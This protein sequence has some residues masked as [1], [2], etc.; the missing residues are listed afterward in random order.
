MSAYFWWNLKITGL[1]DQVTYYLGKSISNLTIVAATG[2]NLGYSELRNLAMQPT[3]G[4]I[5]LG[6]AALRLGA[7][8][9]MAGQTLIKRGRKYL[10]AVRKWCH[11]E[12]SRHVKCWN[13]NNYSLKKM[14]YSF[15]FMCI[16]VLHVLCV[17]VCVV[18]LA[19]RRGCCIPWNWTSR[20]LWAGDPTRSSL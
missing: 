8:E 14:T 7:W 19:A 18:A 2:S 13:L 15:H 11:H 12:Q 5:N 17:C 9:V 10:W 16:C 4:L 20:C 3:P 1:K 6:H